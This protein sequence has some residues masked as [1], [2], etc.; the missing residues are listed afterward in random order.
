MVLRSST[1]LASAAESSPR[2][3]EQTVDHP[4]RM[5]IVGDLVGY[6]F[7]LA[8]GR[9]LTFDDGSD[10]ESLARQLQ[11]PAFPCGLYLGLCLY[12]LCPCLWMGDVER[13]PYRQRDAFSVVA[14]TAL[15]A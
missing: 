4:G 8:T 12:L 11:V 6:G 3:P 2:P 1:R 9:P 5:L 14:L 15:V 13:G 10:P 7:S